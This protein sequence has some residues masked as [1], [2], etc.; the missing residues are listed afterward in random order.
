MSI[1]ETIKKFIPHKILEA[2]ALI[3]YRSRVKKVLK[4][5]TIKP[6]NPSLFPKGINIMGPA[7]AQMGIGQGCR[8][9]INE[10][11]ASGQNFTLMNFDLLGNVRNEDETYS[12]IITDT[13]P[14]GI[15]IIFMEPTELMF[16]C[17]QFDEN[18]WNEKYNIAYWSWELEDFPKEWTPSIDIV[19][20][21]WTPSEFTSD[22]IRK[23]TD[24]PVYTVPYNVTAH[25]DDKYD[26]RYFGLPED[27]F[28]FLIMFDFNSTMVRKNPIGA[29]E[30]Y[31]KAFSKDDDSVGLVIK[32]NNTDM[33]KLNEFKKLL[34]GYNNI[35]YITEILPKVAVNSLIKEVDVFVSLHRAEGFGIVMAEAMLNNTVCIATNWSSNIEFMNK[36]VACMVDYTFTVLK[37]DASPY[38]KGSKWADAN[39]DEAAEYMKKLHDDKE[40]YDTLSNNAKEYI[41]KKLCMD[42]ITEI[43]NKRLEEIVQSHM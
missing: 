41:E 30:A 34:D 20:E 1:K 5:R 22:S 27:K 36:D 4:K 31:K 10:V 43:I 25:T 8:L 18:L 13:T 21:I 39:T 17:T 42:S 2:R 9:L 15:N 38:R 16:R 28:L 24:K 7:K 12:N 40:F 14:Y 32:T 33:S 23:V 3:I 37:K 35:F 29:I 6:Y 26:R 19:D 11:E